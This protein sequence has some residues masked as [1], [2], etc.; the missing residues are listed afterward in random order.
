MLWSEMCWPV[1][2]NLP[3]KLV[4]NLLP[5]LQKRLLQILR[6]CTKLY[7]E[8]G[9]QGGGEGQRELVPVAGQLNCWLMMLCGWAILVRE[10]QR[11]K[12]LRS[13]LLYQLQASTL[14]LSKGHRGNMLCF[15]LLLVVAELVGTGE[16][17]NKPFPALQI[18]KAVAF[19]T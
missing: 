11:N 10:D 6:M 18:W 8:P 2:Q 16:G 12:I 9:G 19:L 7:P 5:L 1:E 14:A 15:F 4:G 17:L 13:V 3:V